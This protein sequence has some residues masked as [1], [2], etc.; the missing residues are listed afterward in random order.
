MFKAFRTI[1]VIMDI[2]SDME[3]LCPNAWLI[4][5]TNP[6]GMVTEAAIKHAGWKKTIGLCNV[7]IGHTKQAAEKLGVLEEDL[8]VKYREELIISTG[9]VYG[10]KKE[11]NEQMN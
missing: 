11:M 1:P 10:I 5:F 2:I 3:R 8:F 7:P 6:A 4:N 9:I